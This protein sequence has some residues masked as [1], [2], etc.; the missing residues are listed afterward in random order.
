MSQHLAGKIAVVT[1][2]ANGI[3][4]ASAL[5][6]AAEGATVA[7]LDRESEP[8]RRRRRAFPSLA[9]APARRT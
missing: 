2:S 1:G 7:L 9:A 3:G 8:L 5:R 6:L 4:R